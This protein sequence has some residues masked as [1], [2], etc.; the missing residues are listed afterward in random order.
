MQAYASVQLNADLGLSDYVYGLGS[1]IFFLGYMFF[2]V[3]TSFSPVCI[4]C[5][6]S[7]KISSAKCMLHS[8]VPSAGGSPCADISVITLIRSRFLL[9]VLC[10]P[11]ALEHA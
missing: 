5:K 7:H 3:R 9:A 4:S 1:G 10:L 8:E 2:Q 11:W 6:S